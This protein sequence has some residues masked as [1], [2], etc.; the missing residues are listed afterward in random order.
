MNKIAIIADTHFGL[1]GNSPFFLEQQRKFF[2]DIFFPYIDEHKIDTIVHLGDVFDKR[3][4]LNYMIYDESKKFFFDEIEKRNL[5]IHIIIGNHD[6]YYRNTNYPNAP[7]LLLNKPNYV[8]YEEPQTV[9]IKGQ[10]ITI[11]PWVNVENVD[12][13]NDV[14]ANSSARYLMGHLEII[15]FQM[16]IGHVNEKGFDPSS[17]SSFEKVFSGHFHIRSQNNNIWYTGNPYETQWG[18]YGNVKGF[19]I[20]D[21]D[22]HSLEFIENPNMTHI[23]VSTIDDF[24]EEKLSGMIVKVDLSKF[25]TEEIEKIYNQYDTFTVKPENILFINKNDF[26]ENADVVDPD[27]GIKSTKDIMKEYVESMDVIDE[28]IKDELVELLNKKYDEAIEL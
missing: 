26:I 4:T 17:L 6:T 11:I 13:T 27:L 20:L 21:F 23:T 19:H 10:K 22:D 9:E 15:G 24:K 25:T 12:K 2:M 28:K 7:R 3:N 16:T 8:I 1:R 5:K 14:I 18:D